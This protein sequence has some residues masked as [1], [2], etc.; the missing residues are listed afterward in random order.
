MKFVNQLLLAMLFVQPVLVPHPA[1]AQTETQK[2]DSKAGASAD[3]DAQKKNVEAYIDLLRK[4]VRQQKAEIMGAVM[5]LSADDAAKFWPVYS[6]YDAEL[7][8]LN[9]QRVMN[10]K[11]YARVYNQMTDEKANDL[12]Q[13][14]LAY[15]KQRAELLA[16]T[17][18][19]VKEIVGAITAARFVQVE[20]QLLLIIDL[21]IASSLPV[22]GQEQ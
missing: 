14:S 1:G 5:V 18:D 7:I 4:D 17:Y 10:I 20:H 15:Q 3:A 2:P 9:D 8:K 6:E 21:Q 13:R 11:E 12:I 16:K 22:V 19:R